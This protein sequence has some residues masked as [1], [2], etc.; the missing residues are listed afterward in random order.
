M[1]IW[2]TLFEKWKVKWKCL[3]IEIEKWNFS[4][5]LEKFSRI[6]KILRFCKIYLSKKLYLSVIHN[7]IVS[8]Y[9]HNFTLFSREKRVKFE[10]LSLFSRNEKWN[11]FWFHFFRE[12]KVKLKCLEIEIEKWNCKIILENSRETRLSQVTDLKL[13]GHVI[14]KQLNDQL[15]HDAKILKK[16]V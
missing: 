2:F 9:M 6:E 7:P 10:M 13:N 12:V 5:I 1:K 3:E 15:K 16:K 14:W 11:D 8:H 4:R